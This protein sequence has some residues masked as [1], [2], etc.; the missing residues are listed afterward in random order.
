[1]PAV[2]QEASRA[3]RPPHNRQGPLFIRG[4]YGRSLVSAWHADPPSTSVVQVFAGSFRGKVL[5]ENPEFVHPNAVRAHE[6]RK[7]AGVYDQK[8]SREAASKAHKALHHV[9][10]DPLSNKAVFAGEDSGDAEGSDGEGAPGAID[11]GDDGG[12]GDAVNGLDSGGSGESDD[13]DGDGLDSDE[14]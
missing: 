13:S 10:E 9:G 3:R 14:E 7:A 2:A 8:K 1:M 4:Q 5:F 11:F 6:K 12:G